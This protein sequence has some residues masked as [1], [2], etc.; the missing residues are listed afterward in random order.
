MDKSDDPK[1][2]VAICG[3]V[4]ICSLAQ[5]V[6]GHLGKVLQYN[7]NHLDIHVVR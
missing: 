4:L 3:H 5:F 2:Q 1:K 7:L 6:Q